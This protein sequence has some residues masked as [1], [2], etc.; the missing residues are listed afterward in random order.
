VGENSGKNLQATA[1]SNLSWPSMD[2]ALV[3]F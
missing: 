1:V 2:K 3:E